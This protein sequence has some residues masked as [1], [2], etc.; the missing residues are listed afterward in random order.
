MEDPMA[1]FLSEAQELFEYTRSMRRDFH[2]HPE[3]GFKEVRTAGIVAKEL[4]NLGL[5]VNTGIGGTGVVALIEGSRPG[6][7]V[8]V[9][10][11]MDALPITEQTGAEYAS[12]NA[13]VMH[14]CGHDGHTAVLLTVAR[15]LLNHRDELAGTVKLTFQP[16]EEGMGGAESMMKDGV[17]DNPKVDLCLALHVWNEQPVGWIGISP[18]PSM[19]GAEIFNIT[20][21]GKGGHGAVPHLAVDP[22]LASAQIVTALQSI[23]ARNV[24]PLEAAVVSV[25]TIHG[26]EAFNVIPPEVK[27][28]GTIRTFEPA[29]RERV[30]ER[31]NQIVSGAASAMGCE[32]VIDVQR[33]TPAT[34]NQPATAAKVQATARRLFP[35]A[36]IETGDHITMGSEDFAFFLEK[37]PGCFFFVGSANHE[38]GFDAAHH[39]PRFDI[40]E[41]CLPR[42]AA[43][44]AAAVMDILR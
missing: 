41:D 10:A 6:P 32:A 26:G 19:A 7:T 14:A 16:A 4:T 39:H 1:D 3:L 42:A 24:A 5:E 37:V 25:C 15:M 29:I 23:A 28:T 44:M 38:K 17:L 40:D 12:Q 8:L 11:D 9:R 36:E 30:L 27:M 34:I 13:G 43:L 18:G 35:K 2:M 22:V 20:V 31:F 21:K 33:L